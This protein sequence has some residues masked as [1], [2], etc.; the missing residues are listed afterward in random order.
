MKHI[1]MLISAA[2]I[3]VACLMAGAE[4]AQAARPAIK[5]LCG[6]SQTPQI[7]IDVD[8][9][10][11]RRD[12]NWQSPEI[13]RMLKF[14]CYPA[15]ARD[16]NG[17]WVLIP[18]GATNAWVHFSAVRF[19]DGANISQLPSSD[20]VP[21]PKPGPALKLPG[22]P[23]VS[24]HVQALYQE[25]VKAGRAA[26]MITIVGDCN[27]EHPV[28]FGRLSAGAVSLTPYPAQVQKAA[29]FFAPS[30]KRISLA[31]SGSFSAAMAFDPTWVDPAKCKGD[32]PL[33]CELKLSNASL[34]IVALG[35]GD[36]F[37]WQA[38]E[39][40]YRHIIDYALANKAVPILMTKADALETQQGGAPDDAINATVR[41]L[42]AE[43]GLPVID[44]GT[45]AKGLRD[46]G[47]ALERNVN[48]QPIE[49]FHVN[50][51]GM[52]ARIVMMLETLAQ[53]PIPAKL[54]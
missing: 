36:T 3:T 45:A 11:A 46:H 9:Y 17:E 22:V 20:T 4:P 5:F 53:L 15:L 12:N 31:T 50:E 8:G 29:T 23:T 52:D 35:T 54:K 44:F 39:G 49:P 28:F 26:N 37:S 51:L 24:K 25:G 32:G 40:H 10:F 43:Y 18:Y 14:Q 42:G 47:L 1:P 7:M 27:S 21:P 41:K 48:L 34:V 13:G 38:F 2:A 30:F 16:N 33:S 19:K 6:D